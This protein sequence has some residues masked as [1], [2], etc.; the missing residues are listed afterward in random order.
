VPASDV[1]QDPDYARRLSGYD[2]YKASI[3]A[4]Y[5]QVCAN[6]APLVEEE[7]RRKDSMAR[8]NALGKFLNNTKSTDKRRLATV[9]LK[10]RK[11]MEWE[12]RWWTLRGVLFCV[13]LGSSL[14]VD[15]TGACWIN[16]IR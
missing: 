14:F 5:P 16:V 12:L 6:C 2:T 10:D 3:E 1:N 8:S 13:T 9:S 11:K 7:I 4:R 15:I